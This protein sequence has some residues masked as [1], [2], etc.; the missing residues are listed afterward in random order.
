MNLI[1]DFY[2][3][4]DTVNLILFWGTII[5]VLLLLIFAIIISNKNRELKELIIEKE[6]ELDDAK[7]ELAIKTE[8]DNQKEIIVDKKIEEPKIAIKVVEKEEKVEPK[9]EIK[10]P[11]KE[12]IK[13][14]P[15]IVVKE[16][17]IIQPVKEEKRFIAEEH[18]MEDD[19][20][21]TLPNIQKNNVEANK[22]NIEI[23]IPT[24]PYERNV[25]KE[26]S[27]NQTSP[28]GIVRDA[29][30]PKQYEN[31]RELHEILNEP[32][33]KAEIKVN[34]INQNITNQNTNSYHK[35]NYLEELSKKISQTNPE[36]GITRTQYEIKQEEDAIISLEELMRKK[37][38]IKTI[39]EEDA[40]ISIE[41]LMRKK[42]K[43][44]NITEEETD[45]KFISELKDFRSDL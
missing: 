29:P 22:K 25:L 24:R 20:K 37:D 14:E 41:E 3:S 18:V 21:F 12:V 23:N 16:Q 31:A 32:E 5:V 10:V 19:N 1:I 36:N 39:D 28:I 27:L 40:V 30:E 38:S 6:L 7:N 33:P 8:Q 13:E 44:Y 2:Q 42:D 35:G 4:L 17:S 45:D 11:P 34:V 15:T 9:V 43:L 26:M